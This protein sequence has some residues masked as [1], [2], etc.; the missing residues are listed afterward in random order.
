M[1][2]NDLYFLSCM[3]LFIRFEFKSLIYNILW[4]YFLSFCVFGSR[5]NKLTLICSIWI[6]KIKKFLSDKV[7]KWVKT[8]ITILLVNYQMKRLNPIFIKLPKV[9]RLRTFKIIKNILIMFSKN[10]KESWIHYSFPK[11]LINCNKTLSLTETKE[12]PSLKEES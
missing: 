9:Y 6:Y 12:K 4:I 3:W 11:A 10:L 8:V 1:R 7:M 2:I 5:N